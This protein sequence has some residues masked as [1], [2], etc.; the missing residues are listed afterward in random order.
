[1]VFYIITVIAFYLFIYIFISFFWSN[2]LIKYMC[3]LYMFYITK[4]KT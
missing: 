4:K 3:I 2:V 1:M